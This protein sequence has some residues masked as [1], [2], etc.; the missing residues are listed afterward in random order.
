MAFRHRAM[1]S[2]LPGTYKETL[3]KTNGVARGG[4]PGCHHFKV[5]PFYNV[6]VI[7]TFCF[8]LFGLNPHTQRKPTD[9]SAKS[10]FLFGSSLAFGPKTH[11][12]FSVDLFFWSSL[13][14]G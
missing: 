8:N 13:T 10:F 4:R 5:T 9:F 7:K 11:R 1:S 3:L 14:E 2:H 6:F 12:I